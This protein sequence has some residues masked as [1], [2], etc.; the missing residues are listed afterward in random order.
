VA[1]ISEACEHDPDEFGGMILVA[2]ER[3]NGRRR[4]TGETVAGGGRV[5]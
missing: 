4:A 2:T 1:N 5:D 3:G